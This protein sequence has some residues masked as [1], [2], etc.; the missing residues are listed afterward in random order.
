MVIPDDV[1]FLQ[2]VKPGLVRDLHKTISGHRVTYRNLVKVDLAPLVSAPGVLITVCE[3][4]YVLGIPNG[5]FLKIFYEF[6]K[7]DGLRKSLRRLLD[8][9]GELAVVNTDCELMVLEVDNLANRHHTEPIIIGADFTDPINFSLMCCRDIRDRKLMDLSNNIQAR[10][11]SNIDWGDIESFE[12]H[13]NKRSE[14]DFPLSSEIFNSMFCVVVAEVDESIVGYICVAEVERNNLFVE[15]FAIDEDL[16]EDSIMSALLRTVFHFGKENDRQ[17]LSMRIPIELMGVS[18]LLRNGFNHTGDELVYVRS[19][20][21]AHVQDQRQ[22]KV[23]SHIEV[24]KI[25]GT[26][27]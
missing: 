1:R 22:E 16:D 7:I 13:R 21:P 3:S 8:E 15:G 25:F 9:L 14:L 2:D 23:R 6:E 27:R 11:A 26:F 5:R 12:K 17:T 24:G 10:I 20:N 19:V 4:G 18:F